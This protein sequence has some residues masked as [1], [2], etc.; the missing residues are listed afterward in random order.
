MFQSLLKVA[1]REV[2]DAVGDLVARVVVAI[3]FLVAAGFLTSAGTV[4]L[5]REFGTELGLAAV[6]AVFAV[7]GIILAA[8]LRKPTDANRGERTEKSVEAEAEASDALRDRRPTAAEQEMM[9]ATFAAV[10]P[11]AGPALVRLLFRN[12]PILAAIAVAVFIFTR[13]STDARSQPIPT[14]GDLQS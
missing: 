3:P 8:V 5:T 10:A 12:L 4:R 9:M 11:V 6:A 1:R 13:Q 7:L 2:D 14:S